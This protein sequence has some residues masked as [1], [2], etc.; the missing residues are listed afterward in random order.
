MGV[1]ESV[2]RGCG[3]SVLRRFGESVLRG[4][5]GG[6]GEGAVQGAEGEVGGDEEVGWGLVLVTAR[7]PRQARV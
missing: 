6:V 1:A 3:E 7:Y 4:F 2:L 5:G